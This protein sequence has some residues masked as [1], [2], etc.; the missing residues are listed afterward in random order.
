MITLQLGPVVHKLV[1]L[2]VLNQ[3]TIAAAR[4]Q[5][6]TEISNRPYIG[7]CRQARG[8]FVAQIRIGNP[9]S[10][11]WGGALIVLV[12][13]RVV[14]EPAEAEVGQ[15][16]TAKRLGETGS[17]AVIVSDG[18]AVDARQTES[19]TAERV[20]SAL[21]RNVEISKTEAPEHIHG[22]ASGVV[23]TRIEL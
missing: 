19:G 21:A 22:R 15:Q 2:F 12:S 3:R 23:N 8:E 10:S 7:K 20:Q 9:K 17:Q 11:G 1:L 4:A 18:I 6:D 5:T 14:L 13:Q 16:R